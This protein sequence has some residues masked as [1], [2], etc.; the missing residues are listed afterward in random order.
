MPYALVPPVFMI[1][2]VDTV[3]VLEPVVSIPPSVLVVPVSIVPVTLTV[4]PPLIAS[5]AMPVPFVE[6]LLPVIT[7]SSAI[8]GAAK[9]REIKADVPSR[10]TL[11]CL[12]FAEM[13][14]DMVVP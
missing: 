1:P 7:K 5:A 2:S 3:I 13:A 9:A 10:K 4:S 6:L 14:Y 12:G 8:T 11:Q